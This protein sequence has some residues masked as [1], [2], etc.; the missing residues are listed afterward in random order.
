M[1]VLNVLYVYE[2]AFREANVC[3]VP[4]MHMHMHIGIK[5][6]LLFVPF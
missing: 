1:H 4:Q 5:G 2:T 3:Q 6:L